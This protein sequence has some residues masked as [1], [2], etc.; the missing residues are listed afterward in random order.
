M[1]RKPELLAPAGAMEQ[2]ETAVRFGADAVYL[3]A[4][5]F[6]LRAYAGNF[7]TGALR[8][9][10]CFAHGHGAKVYVTVNA[11]LYDDDLEAAADTLRAVDGAGADAVIVSDYAAVELARRVAP[12]LALHISTQANTLNTP[13]CLHWRSL[14]ASR[15]VLAREL[16]LARIGQMRRQLPQDLCLEAFVHGAMCA[17]YS[18]RCVLSNYLTGRD[19]NQG[20]CAQ[21]CRWRYALVEEKR[22]GQYLPVFQDDQGTYLYSANDLCMIRHLGELIRAGVGSFKIEGRMKTPYYVATVVGAYRRALDQYLENPNAPFDEGLYREVLCASH[23]PFSTGFYFGAPDSPPGEGGYEQSAVFVASVLA[24]DETTRCALVQQRNRFFD[25]ETLTLLSPGAAV[26][27]TV[28]GLETQDGQRV[29][30][31]PHPQQILR[32][33]EAPPMHK[34]D[35]IRRSRAEKRG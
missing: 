13:S 22:P 17:S 12:R 29:S 34:G 35:F 2:L 30:A 5:R 23:R 19:A 25:G 8:D 16:S 20:G 11:F 27:F 9:G 1:N 26:D 3:G 21:P 7:D 15:I 32:L 14:G 6:G 31:A 18:G 24:Y 28:C 10:V 4:Q 33:H